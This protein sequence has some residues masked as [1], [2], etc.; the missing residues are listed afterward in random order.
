MKD[1]Q[2]DTLELIIFD[3]DG[4]LYDQ[5]KLRKKM[6]LAL[7]G[8]YL[9][10]P[11]KYKDL[12]ILYHFRKER[13][14]HAGLKVED[15][16]KVQ[17][18]WCLQKV[19]SSVAEVR[20]VVNQ[21]IF[22]FPNPYLPACKYAGVTSFFEELKKQNIATAVYSDYEAAQKLDYLELQVDLIVS[23]TQTA[24]N[25]LKPQPDGLNFILSEMKIKDKRNCL[26]IGDRT[27]LDGVCA[28]NAGISFL[29][30][31]KQKGASFYQEL[32][33]KLKK[34]RL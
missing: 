16:E 12:L 14:K 17:Y 1:I 23:S 6:L 4:T 5:A 26:F 24:I 7:I 21:W 3:V 31:N 19:N 9:L 2:W 11:W 29:L 28:A 10:R 34:I 20:R 32:S 30:V 27:E 33:A 22:N 13:E 15:L 18:E 25:S 8:H